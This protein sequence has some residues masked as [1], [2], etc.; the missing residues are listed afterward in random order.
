MQ[1]TRSSS[2]SSSKSSGKTRKKSGKANKSGDSS[3]HEFITPI[4]SRV[5]GEKFTTAKI[6]TFK[7]KFNVL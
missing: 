6:K 5:F 1:A 7:N 4:L 3:E 2:K